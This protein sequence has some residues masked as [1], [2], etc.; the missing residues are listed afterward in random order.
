MDASIIITM[1]WMDRGLS[2]E[3]EQASKTGTPQYGSRERKAKEAVNINSIR[4]DKSQVWIPEIDILNRVN[5][6][7]HGDE[8]LNQLKIESNGKVIYSRSFRMRSMMSS[9]LSNYPYDVQEMF[10]SKAKKK[11]VNKLK[12]LCCIFLIVSDLYAR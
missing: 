8:K 5:D 6:F 7:P 11:L 3:T 4:A 1:E 12:K 2:W 10:L 9:S